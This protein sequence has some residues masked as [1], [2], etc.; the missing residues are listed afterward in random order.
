MAPSQQWLS[1]RIAVHLRTGYTAPSVWRARPFSHRACEWTLRASLSSCESI[2]QGTCAPLRAQTRSAERRD[3]GSVPGKGSA[4]AHHRRQI[5]TPWQRAHHF[6][7]ESD[8]GKKSGKAAKRRNVMVGCDSCTAICGRLT[9]K[10][11]SE[12]SF[13]FAN[14]F[15]SSSSMSNG[16]APELR[17]AAELS[18]PRPPPRPPR[19]PRDIFQCMGSVGNWMRLPIEANVGYRVTAG[20]VE[21]QER[22]GVRRR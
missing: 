6:N 19:P 3:V 8:S 21:A 9:G 12:S 16:T 10:K 17:R 1:C 7:C 2:C 18:P 14:S 11:L 15:S 20:V 5:A 4:L 22:A 13:C